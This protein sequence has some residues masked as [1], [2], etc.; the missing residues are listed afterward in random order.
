MANASLNFWDSRVLQS[1]TSETW[2]L[3]NLYLSAECSRSLLSA[4]LPCSI[5]PK[6]V[7]KS[8]NSALNAK[9]LV[10]MHRKLLTCK[11]LQTICILWLHLNQ[12]IRYVVTVVN[13]HWQIAIFVTRW[14]LHKGTSACSYVANYMI[15]VRTLLLSM[16]S[17]K[18]TGKRIERLVCW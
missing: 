15:I 14:G 4:S 7:V 17:A 3:R 8:C 9:V 10:I 16:S 2:G 13:D 1:E 6:D 11:L 12:T 18:G 5:R